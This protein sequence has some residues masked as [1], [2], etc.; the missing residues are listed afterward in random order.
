[1][2]HVGAQ[3][4]GR[5]GVDDG[6]SIAQRAGL[7]RVQIVVFLPAGGHYVLKTIWDD[8]VKDEIV[9]E[10]P[11]WHKDIL[12]DR[13]KAMAAGEVTISDWEEAKERIKKRHFG[14]FKGKIKIN[15]I[16]HFP[17]DTFCG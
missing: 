12:E 15:G 14:Q 8:I 6:G 16:L 4:S 1:M 7:L 17:V 2:C 11:S 13:K 10:S 5:C 3:P 9:L